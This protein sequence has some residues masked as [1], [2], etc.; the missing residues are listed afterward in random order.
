MYNITI[1]F[2]METGKIKDG[3]NKTSPYQF[4]FS[5]GKKPTLH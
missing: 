3:E 4:F 5:E 2:C 1:Y